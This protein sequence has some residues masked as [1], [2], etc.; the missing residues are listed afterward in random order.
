MEKS[1]SKKK[2]IIILALLFLFCALILIG[3]GVYFNN[4]SKPTKLVEKTIT[5]TSSFLKPYLIPKKD[6]DYKNYTIDSDIKMTITSDYYEKLSA[7]DEEYKKLNNELKNLSKS[8]TTL[9]LEKDLD[10]KQLF[11]N[12]TNSVNNNKLDYRFLIMNSTSYYKTGNITESYINKGTNNY[13]ESINESSNNIDNVSYL[14]DFITSKIPTYIEEK[15]IVKES[16]K[17][18]INDKEMDVN[19]LNI[20]VD[21]DLINRIRL[22]LFDD[23]KNDSK[24]KSIIE[25]YD[26]DYFKKK[27][28]NKKIL[29]DDEGILV[30]IYTSTVLSSV[31]KI[32]IEYS[33]NTTKR[34]ISYE[35]KDSNNKTIIIRENDKKVNEIEITNK[36]NELHIKVFD[37]KD[38][39]IG[40][41]S[42]MNDNSGIKFNAD[43]NDDTNKYLASYQIKKENVKKTSYERQDTLTFKYMQDKTT[44]IDLKIEA[45]SKITNKSEIKENLDNTI[46]EKKLS[47]EQSKKIDNYFN[48]Y[49][50]ELKK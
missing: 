1:K 25:G 8:K 24:A 29:A 41:I 22:K 36:D 38:N 23:L 13:F 3:V 31:K 34:I 11:F 35:I 46:L 9:H 14:Y 12:I 39:N 40:T 42:Y 4:L 27:L 2:L 49:F 30:K 16:L 45:N 15:D 5:E 17:T 32:E 28:K 6:I 7:N 48:N 10:N 21:N 20:K 44:R 50:E 33:E 18:T 26:N 19:C 37:G 47:E 43:I